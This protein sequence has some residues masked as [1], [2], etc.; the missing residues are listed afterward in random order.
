[1]WYSVVDLLFIRVCLIV[2]L[3]NTFGDHFG[4]T[5]GVTCVLAVLALHTRGILH[6]VSTECTSHNV[7]ELLFDKLV[8]LLLVDFFL[9][10][11]HCTLSVETRIKRSPGPGL[12][13]E[14]HGEV[15]SSRWFE[16][17]PGV[18]YHR[19]TML[20]HASHASLQAW[21][22]TVSRWHVRVC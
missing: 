21:T 3:A 10:L 7:V 14:V 18:D 22:S 20:S 5:L 8:A 16:G 6:Q 13:L 4:I 9:P 12:L 11:F 17:E 1:M 15:N 2:G 19:M